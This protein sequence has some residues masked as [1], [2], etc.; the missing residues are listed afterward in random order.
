MVSAVAGKS[1]SYPEAP[2]K[3]FA[4]GASAA[5]LAGVIWQLAAGGPPALI[6]QEMAWSHIGIGAE[7]IEDFAVRIF[8]SWKLG[9]RDKNNGVLIVVAPQEQR[10]RIEV[11]YGLEGTLTDVAAGRIG[12]IS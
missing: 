10:M 1:D 3:A 4:L 8:E 9:G 12:A 11:G 6:R 7:S 2:W 5:A